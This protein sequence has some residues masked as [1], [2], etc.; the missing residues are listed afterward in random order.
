MSLMRKNNLLNVLRDIEVVLLNRKKELPHGSY[1]AK[2]FKDNDD[3]KAVDKILEKLAEETFETL[4]A[5]KNYVF[6]AEKAVSS[7]KK[8]VDVAEKAVSSDK[9]NV[10]VAEKPVSLDKKNVD[11]AQKTISDNH[12]NIDNI[13]FSEK[14]VVNEV[15]DLIFHILTL[16][17]CLD[18]P[19][20]EVLT[21]L[22]RRR[23]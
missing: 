21:E 13:D 20:D 7:D 15:S 2:L 9:K 10:D 1:S 18:I 8:N 6:A 16:L 4:L 11:A 3:K 5:V 17:V 19:F 12:N 23:K 14:K 22:Q